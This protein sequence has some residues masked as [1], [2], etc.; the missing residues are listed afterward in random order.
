MKT[1]SVIIQ[2]LFLQAVIVLIGLGVLAFLLCEPHWEGRNANA[3]WF[4]V[5]FQDPF[6]AYAYVA[7]LSFFMALYQAFKLLGLAR[8]DQVFSPAGA[9]AVR[10]IKLCAFAMI[11]FVIVGETFL[12]LP[13]A[14]ELPP[15]IFMGLIIVLISF[16]IVAAASLIDRIL[17]GKMSTNPN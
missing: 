2:T 12:V 10:T 13:F 6:L 15:P 17:T 9:N 4:D 16:V 11:G 1:Q 7:S 5:Y 14:D 8:I 3:T